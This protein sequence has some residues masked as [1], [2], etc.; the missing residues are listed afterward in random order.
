M[1]HFFF[2]LL[3]MLGIVTAPV[4]AAP[5]GATEVTASGSGSLSLPPDVATVNAA[6]ET[7]SS[8]ANDAIAQ[9][10]AIY[11]RVVAAVTKI[12]V[13]RG[14]VTLSYYNVSYNPR[15]ASGPPNP[16][17]RYGY[18]VSRS[19][20]VKVREI[21]SAGRVSDA[22]IGAGATAI[23]GVSF[24]LA[25]PRT[26]R[27]QAIAKAVAD[28]RANAEALA[29]AASLRIVGTKSVE[30][31]GGEA[32]GPVPLGAMARMNAPTQFDQSNVN[33][34]VSVTVVFLAE[35]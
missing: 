34:S 11:D 25:D 15:P 13:A 23:N 29:A 20:S 18:S 17:E 32:P 24:G 28:A 2:C 8:S 7:N 6:V 19:F 16:G 10:N 14:D 1:R 9:N 12:G 30:L 22:C 31:T 5:S 33:V 3:A 26:A 35:P 27:A 21:G 4:I